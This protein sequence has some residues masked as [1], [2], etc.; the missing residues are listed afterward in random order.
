MD[1]SYSC[2]RNSR[3]IFK[4]INMIYQNFYVAAPIAVLAMPLPLEAFKKRDEESEVIPDE[5]YTIPEYLAT[6]GHKVSRYNNDKTMFMKG[7]GFNIAGLDEMRAKFS[8]YGM[9]LGVNVF[10]LSHPE[11][12]EMARLPE[13]QKDE[14]GV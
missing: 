2:S 13:W 8:E 9:T 7:F 10:I 4:E 5:Y 12:L 11:A 3:R 14:A 1:S 6:F